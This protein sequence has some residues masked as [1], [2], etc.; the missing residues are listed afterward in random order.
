MK[1]FLAK[2]YQKLENLEAGISQNLNKYDDLIN[3]S[4]GDPDVT[5]PEII[6]TK[7]Y[8]D[9]LNGHTKYTDSRGYKELREAIC[10]FYK[11]RYQINVN[12]DEILVTTAATV[13]MYLSLSAV[14]DEG[15][16]VILIEPYFFPYSTQIE[17]NGGVVVPFKTSMEDDYKIDFT[18]LEKII[19]DKT[20]AIIINSPNNPT[21][22]TYSKEDLEKIRDFVV[23]HDLLVIADDIYTSFSFK[24]EFIPISSLEGMFERCITI[25][26]FSK[27]LIMTG[28]RIGNIVAP[29]E[30]INVIKDINDH[31]VYSAPSFSQRAAL[32]GL[33]NFDEI[34]K[35]I[36]KIFKERLEYIYKRI[37]EIEFLDITKTYASFYAFPSIKKT[38]MKSEAFVK[39][40]LEEAHILAIPG[41]FFGESGDDNFR[42]TCT[43]SIEV[44]KEAFDRI[45][46]LKF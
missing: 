21:G 25:N 27:N 28:L 6:L 9:T 42:I 30:I 7:A 17:M 20:K 24:D 3:L 18:K 45:E 22:V 2:K 23:K 35:D 10:G 13:A 40:L 43:V 29:K 37:D 41:V 33:N 16:E 39:K 15:D 46:K 1:R 38:G 8:E 36:Q 4:I 11:K 19:T 5:T 26:S 44:L 31:V 34:E 14:L 12:D 32:H